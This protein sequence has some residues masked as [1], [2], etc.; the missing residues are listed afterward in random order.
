M[1]NP[2]LQTE[3][4]SFYGTSI[5]RLL[6]LGSPWLSPKLKLFSLSSCF[7]LQTSRPTSRR[8]SLL[9]V[10]PLCFLSTSLLT[11]AVCGACMALCDLGRQIS[12]FEVGGCLRAVPDWTATFFFLTPLVWQTRG[13]LCSGLWC[14]E[15]L[16]ITW[17]HRLGAASWAD[18]QYLLPQQQWYPSDGL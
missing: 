5:T 15:D 3:G 6:L 13:R 7:I 2:R 4:V 14:E 10:S 11:T 8:C 18:V 16:L 17:F 1:P 9:M 12:A